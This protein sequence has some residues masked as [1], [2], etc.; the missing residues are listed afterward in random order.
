MPF[1]QD[2]IL[3]SIKILDI[4]YITIIYF[5]LGFF[6]S[7]YVNDT[8]GTFDPEEAE[9]KSNVRLFAESVF[10]IWMI[11]VTVYIARNLVEKI[12]FPLEGVQGFVHKKV[13]ELSNAAVFTLVFILYQ[14]HLRDKLLF[15]SKRMF[16]KKDGKAPASKAT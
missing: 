14:Q 2:I 1:K 3:R 9:K 6:L 15:V 5:T 12:P 8:L 4:G 16:H 11:G 7:I 10:H 13:K